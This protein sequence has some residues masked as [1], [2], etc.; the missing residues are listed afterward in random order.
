MKKNNLNDPNR[1]EFI[2]STGVALMGSSIALNLGL[3]GSTVEHGKYNKD[4]AN[5]LKVGLIGCGGRG[6]GAAAQASVSYTHLDVYKRQTFVRAG[7][8]RQLYTHAEQKADIMHLPRALVIADPKYS[9]DG[10]SQ[11]PLSLIH[12]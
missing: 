7:L 9:A 6:S 11:L 2:K 5:V 1:R 10:P 4:K 8:I 12:I 3:P